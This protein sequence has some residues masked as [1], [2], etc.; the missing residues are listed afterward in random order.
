MNRLIGSLA[1]LCLVSLYSCKKEYS[2][3]NGYDPNNPP[4]GNNCKLSGIIQADSAT[5]IG[6]NS[7]TTTFD[8]NFKGTY[9]VLWDSVQGSAQFS[10]NL[11]YNGDT[12]RVD[13]NEYFLLGTNKRT[14]SFHTHQNPADSTTPA[15]DFLYT[16]D[17][18]GYMTKKEVY[19]N[20]INIPAVRFTYTWTSGNL[21]GVEGDIVV[22]GQEQKLFTATMEYDLSRTIKNF[23]NI[24][25]D[26]YEHA[27][28]VMA[29]DLGTK[30][31]NPLTRMAAT[32]YDSSGNATS[33]VATTFIN[34]KYSADGYLLQWL[35][36]GDAPA[37]GILPP[38]L[39][40]FH[41]TCH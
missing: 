28:Y 22:P 17:G 33:T 10:A 26:G 38:G 34:Q 23:I 9:V 20:G 2:I 24:F 14:L 40:K 18:G 16:Y 4:L 19:I 12:L 31:K 7:F 32:N 39:T 29:L 30:S 8:A 5:G 3:E 1:I 36:E 15:L 21:T 13:A 11:A 25:P 27:P 41:Y 6:L 35:A 37:I